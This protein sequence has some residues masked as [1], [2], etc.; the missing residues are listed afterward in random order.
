MLYGDDKFTSMARSILPSSARKDARATRRLLHHSARQRVRQALAKIRSCED[1]DDGDDLDL[2]ADPQRGRYGGGRYTYN[3]KDMVLERRNADKVM[4]AQRWAEG[5]VHK[6]DIPR[7]D[8]IAWLDA[9]FPQNLAGQHAVYGHIALSPA[10]EPDVAHERSYMTFEK[11]LFET[12]DEQE[13]F[14][15]ER[16]RTPPAPWAEREAQVAAAVE[17]HG[18]GNLNAAMK[19]AHHRGHERRTGRFVTTVGPRGDVMRVADVELCADCERAR[20]CAGTHDLAAFV[21]DVWGSRHGEW[22][23][24]LER[25]L[26]EWA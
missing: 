23:A 7:Q 13:K 11:P 9:H 15:A 12:M 10:F 18:L 19:R 2:Y 17:A 24:A 16:R 20:T 25:Y 21:R 4:P 1:W 8:R 3:I 5:R 14:Y 6:D 22:R 26:K